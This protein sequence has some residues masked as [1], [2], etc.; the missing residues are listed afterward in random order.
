VRIPLVMVAFFDPFVLQAT[1]QGLQRL[2]DRIAVILVENHSP[3]SGLIR[4]ALIPFRRTGLVERHFLFLE[5]VANNA[6]LTVLRDEL[7]L[8]QHHLV[9]VSD[10]DVVAYNRDWLDESIAVIE[11]HPDV[12]SIGARLDRQNLPV[13]N[14][15]DATNWDS[16]FRTDR[17]DY[18]EGIN[19]G[20]F[21][22]FRGKDLKGA[23]QHLD[24]NNLEFRDMIL[25]EYCYQVLGMRWAMT[26]GSTFRHLAWDLYADLDHPYTK[27][28]LS[29]SLHEHWEHRRPSAYIE[30]SASTDN[31]IDRLEPGE[32]WPGLTCR[33]RLNI[34]KWWII[35][36]TVRL[37][38]ERVL[39]G[40]PP[41]WR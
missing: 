25:F 30:I 29:K 16:P 23:I 10:S 13:A 2:R 39:R 11:R 20:L 12:F 17:E 9:M 3:Y 33:D 7:D 40:I 34:A 18:I 35:N 26:K 31:A 22:L 5:N 6:V 27:F 15:P 4:E 41:L 38:A 36:T 14:F 19:G 1:L 24:N 21:W 28:K 8:C 32:L 37:G